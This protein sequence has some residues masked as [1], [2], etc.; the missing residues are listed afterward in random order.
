MIKWKRPSGSTIETADTPDIAEYAKKAGW[1]RIDKPKPKKKVTE[2]DN[3]QTN[4]RRVSGGVGSKN[5]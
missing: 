2:N 1:E 4:S 5:G 3:S